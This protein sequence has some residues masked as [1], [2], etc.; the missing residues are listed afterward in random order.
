MSFQ[1]SIDL[2]N[3]VL[4]SDKHEPPFDLSDPYLAEWKYKKIMEQIKTFESTLDNNHEIGI[5]LASFG[6]TIKMAVHEIGYQ[7]PDIL[8]FYGKIDNQDAE[9]IQHI[10]QLNFLLLSVKRP[11]C[12]VPPRR[13]GFIA[14]ED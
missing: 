10:S 2:Y 7:N 4:Q 3:S 9:L 6:S 5:C 11:D 14:D 12:S 8:Y 1:D 13:I